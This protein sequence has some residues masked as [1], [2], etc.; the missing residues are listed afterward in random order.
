MVKSGCYGCVPPKRQLGCHSTCEEY[1]EYR[2]KIEAKPDKDLDY[3][4]YLNDI[5][6]KN[7]KR[8]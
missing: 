2:K 1:L 7:R 5:L 4:N 6:A 3:A 8:R